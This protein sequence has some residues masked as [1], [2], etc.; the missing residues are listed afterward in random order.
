MRRDAIRRQM[1]KDKAIERVRLNCI[2]KNTILPDEIRVCYLQSFSYSLCSDIAMLQI[3][4]IEIAAQPRDSN[5][6]RV[7][8]RCALTSR[9]R[10]VIPRW[11]LSR[12]MF[13]AI[14][15]ASNMSGVKRASW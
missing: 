7:R 10:S 9:P 15:D 13:R 1:V 12:I 14:A 11:R 8:D 3:A 6:V 5:Y 2:R 4:D